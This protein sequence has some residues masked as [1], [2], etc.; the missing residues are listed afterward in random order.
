MDHM[1]ISSTE[2]SSVKKFISGYL[3]IHFFC[4]ETTCVSHVNGKSDRGN[5]REIQAV[6]NN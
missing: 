2:P 3:V 6:I 1:R 4:K 5:E